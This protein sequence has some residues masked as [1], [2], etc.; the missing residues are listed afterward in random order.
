MIAIQLFRWCHNQNRQKCHWVFQPDRMDV[1]YSFCLCSNQSILNQIILITKTFDHHQGKYHTG[2]MYKKIAPFILN[3]VWRKK[4]PFSSLCKQKESVCLFCR[5]SCKQN[6]RCFF[7]S[8]R[9]F[10]TLKDFFMVKITVN[11]YRKGN[12]FE[13]NLIKI[14]SSLRC[15]N[16]LVVEWSN[17][18][19][20]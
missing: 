8:Y 19:Q 18:S 17:C 12:R 13:T 10:D 1:D 16:E 9:N 11:E 2:F 14:W 3:C 20:T 4:F 7:T 6:D 15:N 5:S